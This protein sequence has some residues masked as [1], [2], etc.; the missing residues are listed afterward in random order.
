[1]I[2]H[3]PHAGRIVPP[4][5]DNFIEYVSLEDKNVLDIFRGGKMVV[6]PIDRCICD[7]ERFLENEPME[8]LGM[9]VCY[10]KNANFGRLREV[11]E[12]D[13]KSIIEKYYIPHHRMLEAAVENE[14]KLYGKCLIIDCHTYRK[15]PWPYEDLS[16]QRPEI[17]IGFNNMTDTVN[18][19]NCM[20][21]ED[22]QT[23]YNTPFSGALVPIKYM[24]DP[25]VESIMLEVRQD[26]D[27]KRAQRTIKRALTEAERTFYEHAR[28]EG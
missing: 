15:E 25:R 5:Y 24:G 26:V 13:R 9:G 17:D 28:K 2:K 1:M 23:G 21:E 18:I 11:T 16:K 10:E 12:D 7:V 6:F 19:I 8:D 20:L 27:V 14:L 3:I 4:E 22:F